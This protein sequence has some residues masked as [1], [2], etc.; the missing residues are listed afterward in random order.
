MNLLWIAGLA[1]FVLVKKLVP[2]GTNFRR[3]GG[4]LVVIA[5]LV[6]VLR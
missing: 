2:W 5:G 1:I 4:V 6:L 3:V